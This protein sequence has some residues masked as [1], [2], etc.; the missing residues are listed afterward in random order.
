MIPTSFGH[1]LEHAGEQRAQIGNCFDG[2]RA[3][4]RFPILV[5]R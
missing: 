1:V 4:A 3:A 2:S 5:R